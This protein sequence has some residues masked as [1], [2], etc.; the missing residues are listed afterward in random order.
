MISFA[1]PVERFSETS[2]CTNCEGGYASRKGNT[3]KMYCPSLMPQISKGTPLVIRTYMT[4]S[5]F[6][7]SPECRPSFSSSIETQNYITVPLWMDSTEHIG[8]VYPWSKFNLRL[9]NGLVE[10]RHF[11]YT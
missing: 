4:Q 3:M 10:K 1:L 11:Y 9:D 6:I 7:N 8:Y 2:Y 5:P